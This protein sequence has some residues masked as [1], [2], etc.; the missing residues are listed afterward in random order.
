MRPAMARSATIDD[1]GAAEHAA[2]EA[3]CLPVGARVVVAMSGGVD[4]TV[5]AALLA[6]AGYDVVGVTLQLYDHGAAIHRKGA[7]CAGQDIHDARA[8][9]EALGV[10][11]YV[12]DYESRF[13]DAVMEDFADAYLRGET[14]VP[15]IRCNQ[16]VKFRDLLE[17]AR[18]LGAASL[19]TGHYVRRTL[20][21]RGPQLRRAVDPARDQS[22]FLF[23]TTREQLDYLRF[24][25]GGLEKATVRRIAAGLGLAVADKPDS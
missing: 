15:C 10:P 21:P 18:D 12:L 7:C 20:G 1:V 3:V 17:V 4:S 6:R 24:P 22:W 2:R 14:P 23:A 13:R 11:H 5:T 16:T 19:A 25:L 8:A 9:A